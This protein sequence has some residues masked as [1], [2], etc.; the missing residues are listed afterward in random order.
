MEGRKERGRGEEKRQR[1]REEEEG[2]GRQKKEGRMRGKK[3]G[4]GKEEGKGFR[5]E[6]RERKEEQEGR[7]LFSAL[8]EA[9]E[10]AEQSSIHWS[11][12]RVIKPFHCKECC[13][14]GINIRSVEMSLMEMTLGGYVFA[15]F[16]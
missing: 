8:V 1:G 15:V 11:P 14:L 16:A 9:V 12:Y 10:V 7:E 5:K 13:C 2:R 6:R 3:R 4:R